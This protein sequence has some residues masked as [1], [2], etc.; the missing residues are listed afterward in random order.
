[1]WHNG[2]GYPRL[3]EW[4]CS[5]LRIAGKVNPRLG[6]RRPGADADDRG[7]QCQI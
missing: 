1:M 2:D 4:G 7:W 6:M 3:S 5:E